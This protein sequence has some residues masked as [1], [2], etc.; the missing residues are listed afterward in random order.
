[1]KLLLSGY[2]PGPRQGARSD[3]TVGS[4]FIAGAL[5]GKRN[6][7]STK[8]FALRTVTSDTTTYTGSGLPTFVEGTTTS[9]YSTSQLFNNIPMRNTIQQSEVAEYGEL[10]F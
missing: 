9:S 2:K 4:P 10:W 7:Y 6:S 5:S 1:M 3:D 8:F